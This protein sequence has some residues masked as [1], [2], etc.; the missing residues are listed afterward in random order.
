[1]RRLIQPN[2]A[3]N[4]NK[5]GKEANNTQVRLLEEIFCHS[6][7]KFVPCCS[8]SIWAF[9]CASISACWATSNCNC[10]WISLSL[11]T[12]D[13][14]SNIWSANWSS[15]SFNAVL[16]ANTA[17][18]VTLDSAS[19]SCRSRS[20]PFCCP[21]TRLSSFLISCLALSTSFCWAVLTPCF[22]L[23]AAAAR[24]LSAQIRSSSSDLRCA[25]TASTDKISSTLG[26]AKNEP[27]FRWLK[28]S[29][30]KDSGFLR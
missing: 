5:V 27:I 19:F 30:R 15:L 21:S 10:C 11:S 6:S 13:F 9:C 12:W 24:T 4:T 18:T 7:A 25:S 22:T 1:M 3:N 29:S 20:C 17:S 28:L 16:S 26:M 23:A 2:T 8:R 14:I